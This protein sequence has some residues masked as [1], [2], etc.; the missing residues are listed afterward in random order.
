M[1]SIKSVNTV[2]GL[3]KLWIL[4]LQYF[5]GVMFAPGELKYVLQDGSSHLQQL[6]FT[7]DTGGYQ[8]EW[9]K[10][11]YRT[12]VKATIPGND[13]G[14]DSTLLQLETEPF[15]ILAV[16]HNGQYL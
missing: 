1:S 11:A 5:K 16:N 2:G 8:V 13:I 10:G 7:P 3:S 12:E 9:K 15:L 4:P 14:I 6:Y